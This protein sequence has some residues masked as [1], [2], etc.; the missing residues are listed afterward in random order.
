MFNAYFTRS[1][2]ITNQNFDSQME[3]GKIVPKK[4][5]LYPQPMCNRDEGHF[6]KNWF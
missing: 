4:Y 1:C 2:D 5:I 3:F 6:Q